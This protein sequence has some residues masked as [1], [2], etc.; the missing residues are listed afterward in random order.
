MKTPHDLLSLLSRHV[1]RD[2]GVAVKALAAE[3]DITDRQVRELVSDLRMSG[4]AVCG[5]P[6]DGYYIA[7]TPE[8]MEE[9]CQFL[10]NRAMH[11]LQLE[12]RLRNIPMPDLLGQLHL[13]T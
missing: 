9:T 2:N 7:E 10:R 12:S 8:E 3:L 6:R 13:N 1:G 11:S 4:H 5:H